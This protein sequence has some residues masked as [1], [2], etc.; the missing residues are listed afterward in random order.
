MPPIDRPIKN[1][2]GDFIIIMKIKIRNNDRFIFLD[3]ISE[4]IN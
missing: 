1:V 3:L 4:Y 2:H